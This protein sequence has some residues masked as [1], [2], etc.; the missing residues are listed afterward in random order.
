MNLPRNVNWKKITEEICTEIKKEKEVKFIRL[1]PAM[2]AALL[3]YEGPSDYQAWLAN[4]EDK[5]LA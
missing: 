3:R 2:E 4:Q 1:S 5:H